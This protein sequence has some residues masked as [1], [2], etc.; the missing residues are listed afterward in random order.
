MQTRDEWIAVERWFDAHLLEADSVLDDVLAANAAAGL[1]AH[2]VSPSQ[3]KLLHLLARLSGAHTILE[4]G[5]LGA[6]STIWLARALPDDGRLL[7]LEADPRHAAV[8]RT[9][10]ARAGLAARVEIRVGAALDTLPALAT[11]A[12][13][14]FD[15]VFIDADK[16]SNVAYLDWALRLARPGAVIVIDNVVRGGAVVDE[17]SDD[18]SVRGVRALAERL[19]REPRVAATV[20]QTVGSKGWD[21]FVLARI[22][23]A[24][25]SAAALA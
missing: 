15:M 24:P 9:N 2:D 6:Y 7:S 20:L 19:A 14:A 10:V 23:G 21:G 12:R 18:E 25:P 1:P 5:T 13:P 8:A 3:G 22:A 11:E 16:R 4:I 17:A